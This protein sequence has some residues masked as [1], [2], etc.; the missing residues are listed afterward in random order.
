M[1]GTRAYIHGRGL[2]CALGRGVADALETLRRG[3]APP[4]AEQSEAGLR[5]PYF[6]IP[7][8][9]NDAAGSS[10][11]QRAR[12]LVREVVAECGPDI[13][14]TGPLFVASSS[15]NVGGLETGAPFPTDQ[16]AFVE[17]VARWLDWRGPV[18]AVATA[19]T[20]A[21][22]ALLSA[23]ALLDAE[24]CE[25]ALVLGLELRNQFTSM[26]FS[27]MQ[28][29]APGP[30][31]PL[32]RDRDGLVLGEA[33]AALY[34]G[35]Q[36]ARWRVLGGANR[37]NG[38]NPVGADRHVVAQV[39]ADALAASGLMPGQIGLVK[40]QAAGSP[41]NDAEEIAG[42]HQVFQPLPPL[43]TYKA[44]LGHTLGASGAAELILLLASLESG[45]WPDAT[46]HAADP[47][48]GARWCEAPAIPPAHVLANILGFG[49]GHCCVVVQDTTHR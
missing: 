4:Q 38:A 37:I 45:V 43:T 3:E 20:S 19:C 35:R 25:H 21:L 23:R 26:G 9:G 39:I 17:E 34:L 8:G 1:N 13:D 27:G 16:Q 48:L 15:L 24:A 12:G 47:A 2:A 6:S 32:D 42:L 49:G 10:W 30:P 11:H 28:L 40:L 31:R 36:P 22:N 33:V 5:W 14:R 44:A 7:S 18:Y 46:P 41:Q 29:I